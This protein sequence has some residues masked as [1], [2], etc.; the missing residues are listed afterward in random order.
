MSCFLILWHTILIEP[1]NIVEFPSKRVQKSTGNVP[2]RGPRME[3]N[4]FL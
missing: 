2:Q 4:R 3:Q 1:S